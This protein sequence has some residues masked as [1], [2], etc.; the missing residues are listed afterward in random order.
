M[1]AA[2][3]QRASEVQAGPEAQAAFR[4]LIAGIGNIFLSDDAFGSEVAGRLAD[5]ELPEGVTVIDFGIRGMH[6]AYELL[7]DYDLVIFVDALPRGDEPGTVYVLE[8]DLD[9]DREE[10]AVDPHGMNPL[11]VLALLDDLGG[12]VRRLLIVGCEPAVLEEDIA[13]SPAVAE[14]VDRAI[15]VIKEL[16]EEEMSAVVGK[17]S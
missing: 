16:L 12:K 4:V 2:E 11:A 13:L 6:L 14:A 5:H 10:V 17:E 1:P 7:E 8:P 15:D 9:F 3:V